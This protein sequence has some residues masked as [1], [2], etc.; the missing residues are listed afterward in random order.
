MPPM[1]EHAAREGRTDAAPRAAGLG[2]GLALQYG[3]LLLG[4]LLASHLIA[5]LLMQRMGAL[6]HPISRGQVMATLAAAHTLVRADAD[7][8]ARQGLPA[9]Q[10]ALAP[11]HGATRLWLDA[12]PDV[13]AFT[14]QPEEVRLA[15]ELAQRLALPAGSA[16]W[17]QVE[18]VSGQHARAPVFSLASWEPLRLRAS[19]GLAD[20]RWLNASLGLYGRYDWSSIL[21]YTVPAS[22]LPV[23]LVALLFSRRLVRPLRRLID[24]TGRLRHG[25]RLPALPLE[26][27]REARELTGQFNAMQERIA[28]HQ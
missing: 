24:A 7:A 17:M 13:P 5:M 27:P 12:R 6:L 25:S 15:V 19:I 28:N 20:G 9:L 11:E 23:L 14:M 16:I 22:I 18:R 10:Q 2:L 26:G 8:A 1:A 3:L 21:R 4:A